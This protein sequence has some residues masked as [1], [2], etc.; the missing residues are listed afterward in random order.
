MTSKGP[1]GETA[2]MTEETAPPKGDAQEQA[3]SALRRM[4][5]EH[6]R[7]T[8][9]VSAFQDLADGVQAE[10]QTFRSTRKFLDLAECSR[11][12]GR[13]F[14]S[15][16]ALETVAELQPKLADLEVKLAELCMK[17][18][19][20]VSRGLRRI[21]ELHVARL[22]KKNLSEYPD[23]A[24]ATE[25]ANRATVVVQARKARQGFDLLMTSYRDLV[26]FRPDSASRAATIILE[27]YK[28]AKGELNVLQ[29]SS[30]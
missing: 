23:E 21:E 3:I 28:A 13:D 30:S 9:E 15:K 14:Q 12:V 6:K 25:A 19:A 2:T 18:A 16:Q 10:Q 20:A 24:S 22:V 11:Y 26:R 8:N 29:D 17:G 5:A 1:G 27:R 7:A 4:L